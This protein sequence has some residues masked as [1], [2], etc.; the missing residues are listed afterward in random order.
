[1]QYI[2]VMKMKVN[3]SFGEK[4]NLNLMPYALQHIGPWET[5]L[6]WASKLALDTGVSPVQPLWDL[7]LEVTAGTLT[8]PNVKMRVLLCSTFSY[9]PKHIDGGQDNSKFLQTQLKQNSRSSYYMIVE[10]RIH[11][12]WTN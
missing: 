2:P 3:V 5:G 1:M 8:W 9:I 12:F 6:N 4:G 10:V 11:Q 7:T